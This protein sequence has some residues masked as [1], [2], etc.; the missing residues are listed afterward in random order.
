MYGPSMYRFPPD[1]PCELGRVTIY[2]K[3]PPKG[4]LIIVDVIEIVVE[5]KEP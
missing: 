1:V 4:R 3:I 5:V 2:R